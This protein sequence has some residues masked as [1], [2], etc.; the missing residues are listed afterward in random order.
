MP[1]AM[2]LELAVRKFFACLEEDKFSLE[3]LF[4]ELF[5]LTTA[6]SE[7]VEN[8][9]RIKQILEAIEAELGLDEH[10]EAID[11]YEYAEI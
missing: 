7:S 6:H 3:G 5:P 8:D 2:T 11:E 10:M 9:G 1:N 4:T